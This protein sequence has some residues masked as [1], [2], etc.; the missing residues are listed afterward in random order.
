MTVRFPLMLSM[1]TAP[2]FTVMVSALTVLLEALTVP[3]LNATAPQVMALGDIFSSPPLTDKVP[4]PLMGPETESIA[5]LSRVR[6]L[7]AG[8]VTAGLDE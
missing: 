3:P 7:P 8:R 5:S 6:A 1:D 4:S 2:P